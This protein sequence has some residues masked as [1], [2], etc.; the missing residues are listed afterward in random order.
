MM[1]KIKKF[2]VL[3]IFLLLFLIYIPA[4]AISIPLG[5]TAPAF[6][7]NSI[8]GDTISFSEYKNKVVILIYWRTDQERSILALKDGMDIYNR[9]KDKGVKVISL[10]AE[11][12]RIEAINKIIGD[13]GIG[14]PVLIDS[15]R[16]V[17]GDYGI[18]VYPTTIIID[19]A[20]RLVY[21]I[22]GYTP[23]YKIALE[24]YIKHLLGEIDEAQLKQMILPYRE[25]RDESVLDAERNYNLAL[26]FTKARLINQAI[27]AVK[28]SIEANPN[29][30]KSHILLGF[31]YLEQKKADRATE[32]FNTA[33]RLDP[34]SHDA[35]TGL[36]GAL[37]LKGDIEKAIEILNSATIANPY[38][39][40]TY[41]EL[42]R[43]YELKGERDKAIEMYKKATEKLIKEKILPSWVSKCW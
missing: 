33:L 30:A 23:I 31:L 3:I 21:N 28:K 27:N 34:N 13:L 29:I 25:Q 35:K 40:M 5:S 12:N 15:D 41:Y 11:S 43:A 22:P 36:G 17:Y 8:D 7:L 32:E 37:I 26:R 20:G 18:R 42:A 10:N 6:T 2:M 9:F 4:Y 39:Q 14:F 16:Q 38:P 19:R 1:K 24:G